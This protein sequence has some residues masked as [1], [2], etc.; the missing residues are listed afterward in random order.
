MPATFHL[1]SDRQTLRN[2]SPF[3]QEGIHAIHAKGMSQTTCFGDVY[4]AIA[5]GA[6]TC[7][8]ILANDQPVGFFIAE[9]STEPNGDSCLNLAYVYIARHAPDVTADTVAAFNRLAASSGCKVIRFKT[10][11]GGWARRLAPYGFFQSAIELT[12]NVGG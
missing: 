4:M 1:V 8:L 3:L 5:T 7:T 6:M 11:R 10:V 9:T 12:Q 2:V